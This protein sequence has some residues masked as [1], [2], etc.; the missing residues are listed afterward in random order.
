[1]D[2]SNGE[3]KYSSKLKYNKKPSNTKY[4]DHRNKCSLHKSVRSY[5]NSYINHII[6]NVE[7]LE[8]FCYPS[9]SPD[10]YTCWDCKPM[11]P[12]VFI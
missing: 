6:N 7:L 9:H 12:K 1:M 5:T 8:E 2:K 11:K 3:L 4:S 10:T